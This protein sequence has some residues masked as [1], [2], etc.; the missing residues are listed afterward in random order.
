M[1]MDD[2]FVN[3]VE[4]ATAR[5]SGC[6]PPFTTLISVTN[7][8]HAVLTILQFA[9]LPDCLKTRT[10]VSCARGINENVSFARNCVWSQE[11]EASNFR[12]RSYHHITW[13]KWEFLQKAT[14]IGPSLFVDADILILQNPFP[15]L[16][17]HGSIHYQ[18]E[19]ITGGTNGGVVW[20]R[21]NT[22]A[23]HIVKLRPTTFE[24]NTTLDQDIVR[25]ELAVL[26][27]GAVLP[28]EFTGHCWAKSA[29]L[30]LPVTYHAHCLMSFKSKVNIMTEVLHKSIGVHTSVDIR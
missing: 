1:K 2:P 11:M 30:P 20:M 29:N 25:K 10:V 23:R 24:S 5:P 3:A 4:K 13:L 6:V 9:L 15:Y 26:G 28:R 22:L 19:T 27:Q 18:R 12:S 17:M 8:H 16:P 21:N 14:A 7:A